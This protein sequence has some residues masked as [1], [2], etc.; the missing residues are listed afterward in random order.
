MAPMAMQKMAHKDGECGTMAAAAAN[1][2]GMV[3]CLRAEWHTPPCGHFWVVHT[4]QLCPSSLTE[5]YSHALR[6][7]RAHQTVSG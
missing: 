1:G 4:S 6:A 7:V 3:R 5:M 2:M